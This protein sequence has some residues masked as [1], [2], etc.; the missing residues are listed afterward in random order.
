MGDPSI[1]L[2]CL[3]LKRKYDQVRRRTELAYI[4]GEKRAIGRLLTFLIRQFFTNEELRNASLD[5]R[6]R[7]TQAL[8]EDRMHIIDQ[9]L[10]TIFGLD[11]NFYRMTKDCAEQVNVVCRHARNPKNFFE[12]HQK[13]AMKNSLMDEPDLV[14]EKPLDEYESFQEELFIQANGRQMSNDHHLDCRSLPILGL[15]YKFDPSTE[16]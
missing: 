13:S 3:V 9:H 15:P 5:G 10:Q 1:G 14:E 8:A 11:Y 2:S 16:N 4:H 7:N 6:V 12:H